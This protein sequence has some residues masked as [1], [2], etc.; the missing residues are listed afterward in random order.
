ME[1]RKPELLVVMLKMAPRRADLEYR[2]MPASQL[3][4]QVG[5]G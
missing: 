4:A 5:V 3:R 1:H 2:L